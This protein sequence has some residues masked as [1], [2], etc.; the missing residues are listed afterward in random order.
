MGGAEI[1]G[2]TTAA[3][4]ERGVP[5]GEPIDRTGNLIKQRGLPRR[6]V[7]ADCLIVAALTAA[8]SSFRA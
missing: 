8:G 4:V 6:I 5:A 3:P 7:F 1:G 2:I